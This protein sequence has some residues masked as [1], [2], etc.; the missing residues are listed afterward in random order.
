[1]LGM[2]ART[3]ALLLCYVAQLSGLRC[4]DEKVFLG[5]WGSKRNVTG[6]SLS[7][8]VFPAWHKIVEIIKKLT[9]IEKCEVIGI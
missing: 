6:F 4:N 1:M 9:S 8:G 5:T 2:N 3:E 7:L